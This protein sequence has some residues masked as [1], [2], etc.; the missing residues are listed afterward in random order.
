MLSNIICLSSA[1]ASGSRAIALLQLHMLLKT[2]L[3]LQMPLY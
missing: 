1:S 2:L 3:H